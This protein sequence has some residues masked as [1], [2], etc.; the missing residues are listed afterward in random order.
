MLRGFRDSE[1]GSRG[2]HGCV[3][4]LSSTSVLLWL[5]ENVTAAALHLTLP[6]TAEPAVCKLLLLD[7]TGMTTWHRNRAHISDHTLHPPSPLHTCTIRRKRREAAKVLKT[8]LRK[9]TW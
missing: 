3:A 8:V 9:A 2:A 5:Q 1:C 6:G 4:T 7:Y